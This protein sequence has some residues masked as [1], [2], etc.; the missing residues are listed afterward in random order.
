[1]A[2]QSGYASENE[3]LRQ[4]DGLGYERVNVHNVEQLHDDF[5]QIINE[6][7]MDKLEGRP[8]TDR[9][10]ERLMTDINSKSVFDSAMQLRDKYALQRDDDSIVY[11]ELM[12]LKQWCQNKFQVTNQVTVN[13][14]YKSR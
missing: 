14:K 2:Y 1:M 8:L 7:H 3:L 13:D 6:R 10:F 12:N 4:L 5:R 11:I 9:E